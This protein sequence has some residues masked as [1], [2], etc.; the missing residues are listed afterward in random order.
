MDQTYDIS[1]M[2]CAN[3]VERISAALK[4]FAK[5]VRDTLTPPQENLGMVGMALAALRFGGHI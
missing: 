3:C 4:P 1:G 2:H 5:A